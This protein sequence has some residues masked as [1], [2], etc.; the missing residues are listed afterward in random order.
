MKY[1]LTRL[2]SLPGFTLIEVLVSVVITA[3]MLTLVMASYWTFLKTQQRM[4][5]ARELQSEVRFAFN[6]FNDAIRSSSIDY[7]A[8]T[9]SGHCATLPGTLCLL[10]PNGDTQYAVFVDADKKLKLGTTPADA[11]F[12]LSP[13]KFSV[14]NVSFRVSPDP[15]LGNPKADLTLDQIQP[16]VTIFLRVLPTDSR[17]QDLV[18]ENQTT[19]SSRQY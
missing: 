2:S 18:I 7:A 12:L 17:Y 1:K 11:Q 6:R 19:I 10:K 4:A 9:G 8:Y 16:K 14:D 3:M 13:Q 5:V 15:S